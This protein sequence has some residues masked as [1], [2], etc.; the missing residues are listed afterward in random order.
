[1]EG[2]KNVLELL[3]SHFKIDL[4]IGTPLFFEKY[5]HKSQF[6]RCEVVKPEELTQMSSFK[7]NDS[8]VAVVQMLPNETI[9]AK[10]DDSLFV[11]DGVKDPGNLG[12]IIRT[13]DW[14]GFDKLVCSID[15]ADFYNPKVIS[16]TMGSFTRVKV[17]YEDL[18]SFLPKFRSVPICYT[19]RQGEDISKAKL[20]HPSIIVMGS[21]SHGV[22]EPVTQLSSK[23]L[24]IPGKGKYAESLNVGVATGIVASQLRI[25]K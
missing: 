25:L 22:S 5:Y 17:I 9:E 7:T 19:D 14:F 20:A 12:T 24:S 13:L 18:T 8:V 11:L 3:N 4:I 16:G 15:S 10:P 6:H 1:V 2:T 21:E 23:C